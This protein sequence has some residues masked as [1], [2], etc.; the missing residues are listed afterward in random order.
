VKP[1]GSKNHGYIVIQIDGTKIFAHR[2]AWIYMTGRQPL[3]DID[4]IN[5]NRA[6]N[7]WNNLREA[8]RSENK[9]NTTPPVTNTSGVKGVSWHKHR[10]NWRATIKIDGKAKHL[11][12]FADIEE[13]KAAYEKT[14]AE[15]FGNF[16]CKQNS[17]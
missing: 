9:A 3:Y 14:A 5:L 17:K 6:D 2:L 1:A 12:S 11:G 8:T 13:A 15:M 7:S 10:K 4:H 16:K